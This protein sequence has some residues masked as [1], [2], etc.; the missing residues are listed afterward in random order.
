MRILFVSFFTSCVLAITA[1]AAEPTLE[2]ERATKPALPA[3]PALATPEPSIEKENSEQPSG[4]PL[5]KVT[6]TNGHVL[7][8]LGTINPKPK[9]F[10]WPS[11]HITQAIAS[12]QLVLRQGNELPA[13]FDVELSALDPLQHVRV[14]LHKKSVNDSG[15]DDKTLRT[16]LSPAL[17]TRFEAQRRRFLPDSKRIEYSTPQAA[18]QRLYNAAL[19]TEDLTTRATIHEQVDRVASRRDIDTDNVALQMKVN[20]KTALEIETERSE[21]LAAAE[22]ACLAATIELL[23][24][25]L[26]LMRTRAEAWAA[27]DVAQ[28]RQLPF[29][30]RDACNYATWSSPRWS[31]LPQ[32]LADEW[33]STV[34]AA[35]REHRS[36]FALVDI[37]HLLK[38]DGLVTALAKKGYRVDTP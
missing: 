4:P 16:V 31:D 38:P 18:A 25:H 7:W 12:S 32:R 24:T 37:S 26:P 3:T 34:E 5:W 8:I 19:Q 35:M 13:T 6:H 36:T 27:G 1:I 33:L 15:E 23:E 9:G 10:K 17:Y 22:I 20:V 21:Y 11:E 2:V 30:V 28:L 14:A 29:M